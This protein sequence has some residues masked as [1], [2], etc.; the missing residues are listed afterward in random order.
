M[1]RPRKAKEAVSDIVGTAPL[2]VEQ[3]PIEPILPES[4]EP[5]SAIIA[6]IAEGEP[7]VSQI[8][9]IVS[10]VFPTHEIDIWAEGHL[11]SGTQTNQKTRYMGGGYIVAEDDLES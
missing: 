10:E 7:Q 3:E 9:Y 5:V 4:T 2:P 8:P 11:K 6:V 1:P